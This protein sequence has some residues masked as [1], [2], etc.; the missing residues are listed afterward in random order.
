MEKIHAAGSVI[1]FKFQTDC[2]DVYAGPRAIVERRLQE[3]KADK[4]AS[5]CI[6]DA[7]I[8]NKQIGIELKYF[9]NP[10]S[11]MHYGITVVDII[12]TLKRLVG[13]NKVRCVDDIYYLNEG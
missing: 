9:S 5:L 3:I 1:G 12:R 10:K 4:K 13:E 11:Y 6:T 2:G 7:L 8:N